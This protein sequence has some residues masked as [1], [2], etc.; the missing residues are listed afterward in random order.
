MSGYL[1]EIKTTAVGAIQSAFVITYPEADPAGGSQPVYCS[2]EY[3]MS[4]AAYPAVWVNYEAADLRIAGIAYTET[5]P[6]VNL[7]TRWRFT[8]HVTFTIATLN[9]SNQCDLIYDQVIAMIAFSAQSQMPSAFR[10]FVEGNNL[11]ATNW[12]YDTI[13]PRGEAAAPGT[14]WGTDEVVYERGLAI[15]VLGEFVTDPVAL[16]L[17]NLREITGVATLEGG[18]PGAPTLIQVPGAVAPATGFPSLSI[19]H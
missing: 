7:L 19:S 3:P 10:Q 16:T 4:A 1:R 17:V 2:L 5:D 13:E 11:I 6:Q 18:L 14:P 9:N 15:Q 8:G 12:S